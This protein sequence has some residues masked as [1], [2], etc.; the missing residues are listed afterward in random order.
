MIR[1]L[2]TCTL[3]ALAPCTP[4]NVVTPPTPGPVDPPTP[5]P[6][7]AGTTPCEQG[8]DRRSEL[9][10][11]PPLD[12]AQ[13]VDFCERREALQRSSTGDVSWHPSC[14]RSAAT[15]TAWRACRGDGT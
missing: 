9:G 12:R 14:Q 5:D 2:L 8:C 13:C 15:C 3:L 6:G 11:N 1:A 4:S 7:P 10:C